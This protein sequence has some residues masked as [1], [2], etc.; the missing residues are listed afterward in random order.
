MAHVAMSSGA[1]TIIFRYEFT[2]IS[3]DWISELLLTNVELQ[4]RAVHHAD[5][6]SK[7]TV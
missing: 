6:C 1:M 7:D 2:H 4:T 5:E 3:H